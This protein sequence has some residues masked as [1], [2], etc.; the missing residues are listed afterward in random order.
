[1]GFE[2]SFLLV[3][4]GTLCLF[5]LIAAG[6]VIFILYL[7][8][9][10]RRKFKPG[11]QMQP[12]PFTGFPHGGQVVSDSLKAHSQFIKRVN[13]S[14]CGAPKTLPSKTA[15]L[16][17]D[18]CSALMD[19]DFRLANAN[20]NAAL[21]NTVFARLIAREQPALAN[22][23]SGQ[24]WEAV[25]KIYNRV[26]DDWLR[27]CPMVASPRAEHDAE[28]RAQMIRYLTESALTKD[29]DPE[30]AALEGEMKR[31]EAQLIR[32]PMAG[33]AWRFSGPVWDYLQ[34]FKKLMEVVYKKMEA[35]GVLA[36][37]PDHAPAGV[38]LRLEYSSVAQAFLPH[39]SPEEGQKLLK[40]YGLSGEYDAVK[41]LDTDLR[42]CGMC[43]SEMVIVPGARQVI[44]ETCYHPID[45]QSQPLPC[46]K[47][48]APLS[49]PVDAD[50]I[51]CPY[52]STENRRV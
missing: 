17:C 49:F 20:T 44:C 35:N 51:A 22:A 50:R 8:R 5:L 26:Y 16:Y 52:C 33:G 42:K 40:L 27:E 15:Y 37:D 41:P 3:T 43:G 28:F 14:Q 4:L 32:I 25:R 21:T 7:V 34:G 30:S 31:L 29:M 46:R 6:A 19:Y 38:P 12:G 47:C 18:Y 9:V 45:V 2:T 48:G 36:L 10:I 23:I 24:D 39:L 1:M 13:C 11:T